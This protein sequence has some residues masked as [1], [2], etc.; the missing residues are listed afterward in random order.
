MIELAKFSDLPEI[1]NII[2]EA[3]EEMREDKNPQWGSTE[4]NYPNEDR[5]KKDIE[6]NNLYIL[7]ENNTIKGFI[8]I[9][10]DFHDYDALIAN[11]QEKAYILHRMCIPKK[12]RKLGIASRLMQ[13]AE[14][15][16]KENHIFVLKADTEVSNTKMNNLFQKQGYEYKGTFTYDDYPGEYNYYEKYLGR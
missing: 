3:I 7:K 11:S 5:F 4:E 2:N 6:E 8:T 1:I 9:A 10:K 12:Y 15:L 14:N 16:A 13:F